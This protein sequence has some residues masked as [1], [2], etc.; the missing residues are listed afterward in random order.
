MQCMRHQSEKEKFKCT[1]RR[2]GIGSSSSESNS[3][4]S[5]AMF[6]VSWEKQTYK[7]EYQMLITE[8]YGSIDEALDEAPYMAFCTTLQKR[9]AIEESSEETE[10]MIIGL[11]NTTCNKMSGEKYSVLG[12]WTKQKMLE[13]R[14]DH[15][16][17]YSCC[18]PQSQSQDKK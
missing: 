6:I 9:Q 15:K 4:T 17:T 18:F 10:W 14:N 1:N 5:Y 12:P 8:S 13:W 7:Q 11:I 2:Q 16:C 3:W